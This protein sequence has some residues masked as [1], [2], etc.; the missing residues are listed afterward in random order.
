V[1]TG[2]GGGSYK[3]AI[4]TAPPLSGALD[5]LPLDVL[6]LVA[7]RSVAFASV[8]L[9]RCLKTEDRKR[10]VDGEVLADPV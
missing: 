4:E 6:G 10:N 2:L 5:A 7:E 8:V 3:P 1:L 9:P